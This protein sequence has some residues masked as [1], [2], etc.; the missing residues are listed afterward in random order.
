M[1]SPMGP[2]GETYL[3]RL[4]DIGFGSGA[5]TKREEGDAC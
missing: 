1:S 5:R 2:T 3:R 4:S